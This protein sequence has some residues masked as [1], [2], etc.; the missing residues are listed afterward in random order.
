MTPG[1]WTGGPA[2]PATRTAAARSRAR[3]G[4][5]ERLE[6]LPGAAVRC[7]G[8]RGDPR[9]R[10]G[11]RRGQPEREEGALGDEPVER[12]GAGLGAEAAGEGAGGHVYVG[13]EGLDGHGLG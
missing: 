4:P 1:W 2:T 8:R 5:R 7:A 3:C 11:V 12:G 10:A 9:R 6:G 13:G